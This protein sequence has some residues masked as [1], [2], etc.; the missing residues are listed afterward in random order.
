MQSAEERSKATD[1][2]AEIRRLIVSSP[3]PTRM[4]IKVSDLAEALGSSTTPVRE[5]LSHLVG[6]GLIEL[7]PQKGFYQTAVNLRSIKCNYGLLEAIIYHKLKTSNSATDYELNEIANWRKQID[8]I[9]R[10]DVIEGFYLALLS[11][12]DN[13]E[14]RAFVVKLCMKTKF[15]RERILTDDRLWER[16]L[17]I[18][19]FTVDAI[20]KQ[21]SNEAAKNFLKLLKLKRVRLDQAFSSWTIEFLSER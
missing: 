19:N 21:S 16:T 17:Q 12:P 7:V 1:I 10:S 9:S 4:E 20:L 11:H 3:L 15:I 2:L 13:L 5:A 14:G 18:S 8:M 6:E